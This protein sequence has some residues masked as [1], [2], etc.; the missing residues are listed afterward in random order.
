MATNTGQKKAKSTSGLKSAVPT[1]RKVQESVRRELGPAARKT[2]RQ[3]GIA[4]RATAKAAENTAKIVA[5][6]AKVSARELRIRSLYLKI[7]ESY[8]RG[9]TSGAGPEQKAAALEPLVNQ[10]DKLHRE[11]ASLKLRE[12]KIRS[13]K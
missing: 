7:G 4:F 11:I 9:G 3:I 12:K 5:L 13:G 1:V 8:Y 10:V 2:G 6:R